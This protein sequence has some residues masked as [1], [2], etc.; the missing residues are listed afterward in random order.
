MACAYSLCPMT[1]WTRLWI[2]WRR[3]T[4]SV[5]WT[6]K[7]PYKSPFS[8]FSINSKKAESKKKILKKQR[9]LWSPSCRANAINY[10][11]STRSALK[12]RSRVQSKRVPFFSLSSAAKWAKA[13]TFRTSS[14]GNQQL[15]NTKKTS[16][17]YNDSNQDASWWSDCHMRT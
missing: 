1:I 6:R 16:V 14:E 15:N 2:I 8:F 10:S 4:L 12:L 11:T 13:S 5:N 3:L 7:R 17:L 9:Y